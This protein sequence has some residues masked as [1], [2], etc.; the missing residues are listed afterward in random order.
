MDKKDGTHFTISRE[1]ILS[2]LQ[3]SKDQKSVLGIFSELLGTGIFL[4]QVTEIRRDEDEE[5]I[6]VVIQLMSA[7]WNDTHVLYLHEIERIF[8][9]EPTDRV[10]S[11]DDPVLY[12]T[13]KND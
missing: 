6:V 8:S 11:P 4:C 9:F 2:Q 10:T 12:G 13:R 1:K 7:T 3:K 5:D